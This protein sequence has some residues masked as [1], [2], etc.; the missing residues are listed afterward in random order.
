MESLFKYITGKTKKSH[1]D[2]GYITLHDFNG[3]N[4]KSSKKK[5]LFNKHIVTHIENLD[6]LE[7]FEGLKI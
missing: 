4:D 5:I 2:F 3:W 6:F 7:Y 1:C